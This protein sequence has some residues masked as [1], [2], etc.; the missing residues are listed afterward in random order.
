MSSVVNVVLVT[1]HED[2]DYLPRIEV[3]KAASR[4]PGVEYGFQSPRPTLFL[5]GKIHHVSKY[6]AHV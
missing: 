3:I 2:K 6:T 5:D 4:D 1:L